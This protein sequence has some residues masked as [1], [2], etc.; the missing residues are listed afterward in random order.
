MQII[1]WLSILNQILYK[2]NSMKRT[3]CFCERE[4]I[5]ENRI[6]QNSLEPRTWHDNESETWK[7]TKFIK[8]NWKYWAI[9][10]I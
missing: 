3:L 5:I 9:E 2:T 7:N 6:M 4:K 1:F 8:Q 10:L